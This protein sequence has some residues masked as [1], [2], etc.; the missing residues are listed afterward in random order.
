MVGARS[1]PSARRNTLEVIIEDWC[2]GVAFAPPTVL[3]E[4]STCIPSLPNSTIPPSRTNNRRR[5]REATSCATCV[6]ITA[7]PSCVYACPHD[8]AHRVN[9]PEFSPV[10]SRNPHC[11][12]T[13]VENRV[14]M[15]HT[16]RKWFIGSA[17]TLAVATAIYVPYALRSPAGTTRRQARSD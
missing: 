15:D 5:A 9:P 13:G 1:D 7:E 11:V 16:H 2:I 14:L 6:T 3:D 10:C 8:A 4:I 17:V 12:R